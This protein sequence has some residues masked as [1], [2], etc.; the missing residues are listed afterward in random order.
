MSFLW[1]VIGALL[2]AIAAATLV[3]HQ[4]R[5]HTKRRTNGGAAL[6]VLLPG[7]G[8]VIYWALRKPSAAEIESQRAAQ[9][10]TR[11]AAERRPFDST[12]M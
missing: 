6:V 12:R 11:L 3:D 5:H 7:L 10:D 4:H 1:I 8:S 9:E 2:V